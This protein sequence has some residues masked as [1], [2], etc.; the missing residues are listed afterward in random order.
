MEERKKEKRICLG[1]IS[2]DEERKI[3]T[4]TYVRVPVACGSLAGWKE[5]TLWLAAAVLSSSFVDSAFLQSVCFLPL[6][7]YQ[8]FIGVGKRESCLLYTSPSPRD[9][10]K[11]RMPSS[12]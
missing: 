2:C 11:S 10:Q 4:R 7:L 1:S 8:E 5:R 6:S 12:A 9:R 3:I